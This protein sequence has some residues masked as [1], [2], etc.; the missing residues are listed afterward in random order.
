MRNVTAAYLLY[1]LRKC[2]D[3]IATLA[4]PVRPDAPF[5]RAHLLHLLERLMVE[6]LFLR[7]ASC[8]RIERLAVELRHA[9]RELRRV[10]LRLDA[11]RGQPVELR[12][13]GVEA[14]VL[15]EVEVVA[16]VLVDADRVLLASRV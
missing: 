3:R 12:E 4:E 5:A 2:S 14:E 15:G 8:E 16:A 6:R 11:V 9:A 13:I 10:V 7:F 1:L